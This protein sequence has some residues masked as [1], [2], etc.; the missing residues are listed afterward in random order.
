MNELNLDY[1]SDPYMLKVQTKK[2]NT[3][4]KDTIKQSNKI[5]FLLHLE[6]PFM[7]T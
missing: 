3:L 4:A 7:F 6:D 2:I 1:D 5:L